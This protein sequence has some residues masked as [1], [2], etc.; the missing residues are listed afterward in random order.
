MY[1]YVL[2]EMAEAVAKE[3]RVDHNEVL[4]VVSRNRQC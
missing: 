2:E 1:D 3:L 4:S